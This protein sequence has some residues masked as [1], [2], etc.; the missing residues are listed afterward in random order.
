M[1]NQQETGKLKKKSTFGLSISLP[2]FVLPVGGWQG[3]K[4]IMEL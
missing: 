2:F 4:E 1:I 3:L